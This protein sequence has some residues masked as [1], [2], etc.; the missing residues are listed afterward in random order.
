[1]FRVF[2]CLTERRGWRFALLA[3]LVC[4]LTGLVATSLFRRARATHER[5]RAAWIATAIAV[6]TLEQPIGVAEE[7]R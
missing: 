1:M 4:S 7:P 2:T 5:S 6:F 3:P